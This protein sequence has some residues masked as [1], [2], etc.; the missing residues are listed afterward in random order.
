MGSEMCIRDRTW[1][2]LGAGFRVAEVPITFRDRRLGRS[3][4]TP[5]IALEAVW[6]LPRL[7]LGRGALNVRSAVESAA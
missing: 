6:V 4:M 3:K 7:R 2:A 1:R 5:R